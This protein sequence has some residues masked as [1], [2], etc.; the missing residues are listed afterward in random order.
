VGKALINR[1][2]GYD[3]LDQ[4][5]LQVAR[6]MEFRPAHSGDEPVPVWVAI[7]LVFEA[8]GDGTTQV[9]PRMRR[10]RPDTS[11]ALPSSPSYER[12]PAASPARRPAAS[13]PPR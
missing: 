11:A 8:S 1:S 4:A 2:S 3:A 10:P 9:E 7:P 5:A 6:T 13:P 12:V